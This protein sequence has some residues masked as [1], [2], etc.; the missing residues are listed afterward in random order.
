MKGLDRLHDTSH[1]ESVLIRG[2]LAF[3]ATGG[4]ICSTPLQVLQRARSTVKDARS[5]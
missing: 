3:S 5:L 4:P 1:Q 2:A